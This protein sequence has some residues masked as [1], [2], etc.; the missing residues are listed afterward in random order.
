[1]I[2][3]VGVEGHV[4]RCTTG[5]CISSC[6]KL[7]IHE[8]RSDERSVMTV[9]DAV[10]GRAPHAR[11][12]VDWSCATTFYTHNTVAA[13]KRLVGSRPGQALDLRG[14]DATISSLPQT[15]PQRHP[16]AQR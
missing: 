13:F 7:F 12:S 9:A 5:P 8:C 16:K 14:H 3:E 6:G 4:E 1:M 15:E 11:W 10:L 2:V